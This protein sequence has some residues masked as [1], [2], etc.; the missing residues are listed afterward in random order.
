MFQLNFTLLGLLLTQTIFERKAGSQEGNYRDV[1]VFLFTADNEAPRKEPSWLWRRKR[2]PS[3][4]QLWG[5]SFIV[6][7]YFL[8]CYSWDKRSSDLLVISCI[9]RE[10]FDLGL[11]GILLVFELNLIFLCL[12]LAQTISEGK[13]GCMRN[14]AHGRN[15]VHRAP[16]EG[17]LRSCHL[18]QQISCP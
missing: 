1:A 11:G 13:A 15:W 7:W 12:F 14:R 8:L 16:P 4:I 17:Y 2:S 5:I 9:I 18:L 6:F 10:E 3:D